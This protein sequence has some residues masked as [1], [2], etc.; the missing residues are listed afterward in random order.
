MDIKVFR[1]VRG[2]QEALYVLI[3]TL[4]NQRSQARMPAVPGT[5]STVT[6]G[7]RDVAQWCADHREWRGQ[8]QIAF[9]LWPP[10]DS[11]LGV[12]LGMWVGVARS[13]DIS[14]EAGNLDFFDNLPT[15][16]CCQFILKPSTNQIKYS[17]WALSHKL[18]ASLA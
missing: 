17:V 7:D 8:W 5:S 15:L 10:C 9:Q 2:P 14:E 18:M 13:P 11:V 12:A 3:I 4:I 6:T 1:R 16:K